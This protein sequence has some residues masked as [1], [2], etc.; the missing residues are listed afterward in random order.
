MKEV[1]EH[2]GGGCSSFCLSLKKT[3]S[4]HIL[5]YSLACAD[6]IKSSVLAQ[7][8]HGE[9]ESEGRKSY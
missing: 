9:E 5:P 6:T 3:S 1:E 8:K 4:S 7:R 2:D